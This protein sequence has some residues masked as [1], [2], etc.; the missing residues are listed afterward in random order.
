MV[1]GFG[2]VEVK[3]FNWTFLEYLYI[4]VHQR[5]LSM[6]KRR[7]RNFGV[8]ASHRVINAKSI[9]GTEEW[10]KL[11]STLV[12]GRY[13]YKKL[14]FD[15]IGGGD[16]FFVFNVCQSTLLGMA[17]RS[18]LS[19]LIIGEKHT[20]ESGEEFINLRLIATQKKQDC[21]LGTLLDFKNEPLLRDSQNLLVTKMS[22]FDVRIPFEGILDNMVEEGQRIFSSDRNDEQTLVLVNAINE[23][24][25]EA[26]FQIGSVAY[27]KRSR[28]ERIIN[29]ITG[30]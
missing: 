2:G 17:A 13:F 25:D 15:S 5:V 7:I 23:L 18:K 21:E 16:F 11:S 4:T 22:D 27:Y 29:E 19:S 12:T 8:F 9:D 1:V 26:F 30:L 24:Q 10:F 28:I 14:S 6:L 20:N 3:K